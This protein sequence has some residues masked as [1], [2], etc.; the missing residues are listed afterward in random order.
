MANK[1]YLPLYEKIWLKRTFQRVMD[2]F[3]L[4]L[5]LMLVSVRVLSINTFTLPLF[6][7]FL[8]E[9]WFTIAWIVILNTKWSPAIT[10]THI[11]RLMQ[12]VL[13]LPP[14][15]MLV[16]TADPIL[17]PPIITVNTVLSLLALDYPTNKLACYVSDDGCSPLTLYALVEAS[18]FAKFWVPF[19]KKYNVQVRAPFRYFSDV[20][21]AKN[22]GS[23]Q[24][25]QEWLR[26]KD[27]YDNLCQKIED[28]TRKPIPFKLD[29]EFVVFS[30]I[31]QRNH[32][33][34]IKVILEN[35]EDISN[36]LPNLVY[37]SREKRP[38]YPHNYKAGAM[39]V[40]TRVSGLMTN[41]PFM[42][43][44]DCDMFV[45]NPKIVLHAMCIF[46]DS[47]S[48]N[49]V[50]FVQCFQQ[51]Y[52]GIKEDPFG[53]QWVAAFEYIIRGMAGLQGPYY[54][55]TS[56]FH[57]RNAIYGFYPDEIEIGRKGK[58]ADE[59]LTQ[60][61]GS[62][63]T[64]VK[65][66]AHALDRSS[67]SPNN[68]SPSNFVEAAI[69]VADC[70]YEYETSWGKHMGWLYGSIT[71]DALT[72]LSIH[73]KGWRSECCTPDPF[74]FSGCT[75]KSLLSTMIQQKRWAS[76][77]TVVFFG[78]HSPIIGTLF[79]KIQ[80]RAA[81]S[82]YWIVNWG[83]RSA[84]QFFYALL[85]AHCIITNTSI[86][87]KGPSLWIAIA[88]FVIYK[89]HSLLEYLA[90]GLSVRQWLNNQR[91]SIV[92]STSAWFLGFLGGMFKLLGISDSVFEITQKE[93]S[94]SNADEEGA[95]VGRFT[96]DESPVF[97]AGTTIL[98]VQLIALF[99][100]VLGL[101]PTH[102]GNESGLG[103]LTCVLYLL[104][105]YW[106]Y[107]KGLFA[108]GKYGIPLSVICKSIVLAFVFVHFCRSIVVIG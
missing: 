7:A 97:V 67:Y 106:P 18:K 25:K 26:I 83:L 73:R 81:L 88:L 24:F 11:D 13:E 8:C 45:N 107:F 29:G 49:E 95:N 96:F 10:I 15:D 79:G 90:I 77:L 43:N 30:N 74:A 33:S 17:E 32:P 39:N 84:F 99:I 20:A 86:F 100:W 62:S 61:F 94:T 22:E 4:L 93:H 16:T 27:M 60:Q 91:M 56:T 57:K 2:I 103:E 71:E 42:L 70:G 89:V 85:P 66:V 53:N 28:M 40:L 63:K 38:L 101:Q 68:I 78:K 47:K 34:I 55:G 52:D 59:I 72:G 23:P 98:L 58:V 102:D 12:Q 51:F 14:V 48:G 76:G 104:M 1:G 3:V 64:F 9:S 69:E 37:I 36:G 21:T 50:A 82:Y 5:L 46:M 6:L 92:A 31:E 54:I 44:V 108:K 19:C 80:F 105:C 87:P 75:P 41:A 65:S 35:K